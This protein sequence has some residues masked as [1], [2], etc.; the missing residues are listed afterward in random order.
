MSSEGRPPNR[1]GCV[2]T[3]VYLL[4]VVV[5]A[6]GV[7]LVGAGA[8]AYLLYGHITL[9]GVPGEPVRVTIPQGATGRD[10]GRI[11]AD[12]GLIEHELMLRAA[13]YIDD[14][15]RTIKHGA[16]DLP[17]GLSAKQLLDLLHEGPLPR[18]D[19]E[20]VPPERVV[21]IPEGLTIR[22][23]AERFDEPAA[24]IDAAS[25]P[26]LIQRLGVDAPTLEGFLMPNTYYFD[27]KPEPREVVERM[28]EQFETE[29]DDLLRHHAMQPGR[30]LLE[31]VTVA[32]LVEE[33]ARDDAERP[34]IASVIYNRLERGMP[35]QLDATLQ[36]A[37]NK[38]AQRMLHEDKEVDSPYNT[39][40]HAG[41]PPGPISNPGVA[42]LRAALDPAET[43]YYYFVSNADGRTHT[44][45]RTAAEHGR[46][47]ARYRREMREQRRALRNQ[48]Q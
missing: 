45:S 34:I 23:M 9:E 27:A 10:A 16:Y 17:A 12:A 18:F 38:Y 13:I 44:F 31:T 35:L 46:A 19:P 29:M 39:Y 37:L 24:F 40:K 1:R 30:D 8:G 25:D 11:L 20:S 33:E 3:A 21:R 14:S 48:E 22:Q 2:R 15:G 5:V 26:A 47:V 6:A 42:S 32:S 28:L 36:F 4:L 43:D 7:L 41:L